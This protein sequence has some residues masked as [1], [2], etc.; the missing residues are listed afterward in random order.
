M[1]LLAEAEWDLIV[2]LKYY[3]RLVFPPLVPPLFPV[4]HKFKITE[5]V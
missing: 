2:I 3:I 1:R 5:D 4:E